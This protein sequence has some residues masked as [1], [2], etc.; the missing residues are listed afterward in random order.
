[1][2]P[3]FTTR[4]DPFRRI[5]RMDWPAPNTYRTASGTSGPDYWQQRADYTIAA[6]LD[7]AAKRIR[8][9]VGIRYTNNSPDTLRSVWLQ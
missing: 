3:V 2:R 8:G 5:D 6:T 1:M 7:T 9:T 4:D